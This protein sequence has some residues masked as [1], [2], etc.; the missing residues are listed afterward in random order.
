MN[1]SFPHRLCGI[2]SFLFLLTGAWHCK[3]REGKERLQD[4]M[5]GGAVKEKAAPLKTLTLPDGT[6][7]L[8]D[9]RTVITP[10]EGFGKRNR[11]IQL[12]GEAMLIVAGDAGKPFVIHT[13][14]LVIQVLG[15]RLHVDAFASSP[16]EQVDLLE[17]KLRVTKSYHSSTDNQP[18]T[19]Q[20]GEMVMINRDIDLME[21]ETL[22]P[23]ERKALE[24]KFPL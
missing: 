4:T 3:G 16:G 17:G 21:K 10:A 9:A 19:L 2:L 20:A 15:T 12:D 23:E 18:E 14:N 8:M 22:N 7:V 6:R 1:Y 24:V 13:R 11:D 5:A